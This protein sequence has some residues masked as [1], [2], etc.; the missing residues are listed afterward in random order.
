MRMIRSLQHPH[1]QVD[2]KN[3]H[4]N[5]FIPITGT[6][7]TGAFD[8]L[9]ALGTVARENNIWF[10]V[11]GAFGSFVVLDPKRRH[12]VD[13]L[14][15]ADSLAFDFHKWLHAPY[16]AGCV[17]LREIA[18]LHATFSSPRNYLVGTKR[19]FAGDNPWFCEMGIELSR[20]CR[21][22][23]VWFN[24]KE[25][26]MVR[27]GQS[28]A[29]NCDQAQYLADLLSKHDFIRVFT[30]ISLNIVN[31]R[32]EPHEL[33]DVDP[34][35]IDIFNDEIV[36]DLQEQGIAVPSTARLHDRLHIRVCIT[37]H[38][39][40]L[41]DFDLFVNATIDLCKSRVASMNK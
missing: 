8:D 9:V 1:S 40:T 32:L 21:A 7:T 12:L 4:F 15:K 37:N 22:L 33:K 23:K 2:T 36:N 30:P 31:F 28:I 38:R 11:D 18:M 24:I 19:G 20:P 35:T 29:A 26:G 16:A 39:S 10:H 25:H 6:V 13:G 27:L 3:L 14:S 41:A 17:L 34:E 5:S